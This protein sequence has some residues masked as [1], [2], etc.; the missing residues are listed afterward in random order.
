MCARHGAGSV[1]T[2]VD[3]TDGQGGRQKEV[4]SNGTGNRRRGH[5]VGRVQRLQ[6]SLLWPPSAVLSARLARWVHRVMTPEP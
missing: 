6:I 2:T 5:L 3:S 1:G 4:T